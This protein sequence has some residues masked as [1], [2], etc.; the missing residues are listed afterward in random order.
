MVYCDPYYHTNDYYDNNEDNYRDLDYNKYDNYEDKRLIDDKYPLFRHEN[1]YPNRYL[2]EYDESP[3]WTIER[4]IK[5][6][7]YGSGIGKMSSRK[8]SIKRNSQNSRNSN[9]KK[10]TKIVDDLRNSSKSTKKRS[11]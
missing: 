10:N 11:K 2:R 1:R 3:H 5:L 6:R 8:G 9:Y 4:A 7:I